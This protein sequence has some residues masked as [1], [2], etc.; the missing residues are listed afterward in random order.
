MFATPA[1]STPSVRAVPRAWMAFV[2]LAACAELGEARCDEPADG[3]GQ[4]VTADSQTVRTLR[5]RAPRYPEG[6]P[7]YL[8]AVTVTAVDRYDETNTG[9]TGTVWV[10]EVTPAGDATDRFAPC[11]LLPGGRTRVCAMSTFSPAFA[12]SGYRPAVGDLVDIVGGGYAEFTCATCSTPFSDMNF[13]PQ[14][15]TPTLRRAG[16]APPQV[17][18]EVTLD[19]IVAHYRELMGILV[20]VTDVTASTDPDPRFGE[21][22]I[23]GSGRSALTL[24]PQ[25]TAIPDAHAGTHW[26]RITGVVTYFYNPKLLPRSPDDLVG[27][28]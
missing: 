16:V 14:V 19:D 15:S 17:P 5:E 11:P 26:D 7:V 3:C 28:R 25:L 20:T 13:L 24:A 21:M 8:R 18:V 27:Q 22:A 1:S 6:A 4:P 12:P 9:R 23:A 10:Q 2:G